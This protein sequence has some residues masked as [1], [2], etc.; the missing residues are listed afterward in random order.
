M[1]G[2]LA[3]AGCGACY[4]VCFGVFAIV[5]LRGCLVW[6]FAFLCFA[7]CG[8]CWFV[9]LAVC[10]VLFVDWFALCLWVLMIACL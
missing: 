2:C 6:V 1:S 7:D 5:R 8:W 4:L 10:S 3:T 9:L